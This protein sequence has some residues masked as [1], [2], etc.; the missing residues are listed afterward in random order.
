MSQ[1]AVS[2]ERKETLAGRAL[3]KS[4]AL[5]QKTD[6]PPESPTRKKK[7]DANKRQKS[8]FEWLEDRYNKHIEGLKEVMEDARQA[9][10]S[11]NSSKH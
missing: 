8:E 10:N 1:E 11:K 9:A 6:S 5:P 3:F 2:P 4:A 7:K